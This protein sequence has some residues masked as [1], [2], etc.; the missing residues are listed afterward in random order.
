MAGSR[1]PARGR[2]GRCA[3]C[4]RTRSSHAS[5]PSVSARTRG[6]DLRLT[7]IGES[8]VAELLGE[9][10]RRATPIVATYAR[11]EAVD[12]RVRPSMTAKD[13]RRA[14]RGGRRARSCATSGSYVWATGETTWSDAIGARL[15]ELGW[16]LSIVE[17]GTGGSLGVLFGD[18]RGSASTRRSRSTPRPRWPTEGR[19]MTIPTRTRPP[20]TRSNRTPI[21]SA[22]RIA[23]AS[24]AA[25]RWAWPYAQGRAP[26][27]RPSRSRSQ[28][29]RAT[30]RCDGSSSSPGRWAGSRVGPLRGR[31]PAGDPARARPHS[32]GIGGDRIQA[33]DLAARRRNEP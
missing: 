4:G 15:V 25:R 26:A 1:R 3:R 16:T 8:E 6:A 20:A 5:R 29:R 11:A 7:G 18:S 28:C 9:T 33:G 30:G 13:G 10:I 14:G 32:V 31:V 2:R 27:T 23:L 19:P 21:S 12:V 24:S 17:I 22:T